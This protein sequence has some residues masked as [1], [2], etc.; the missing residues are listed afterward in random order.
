MLVRNSIHSF[1]PGILQHC[2]L[3]LPL[4]MKISFPSSV[5]EVSGT[6][7]WA[8]IRFWSWCESPWTRCLLGGFCVASRIPLSVKDG[9][10]EGASGNC[11]SYYGCLVSCSVQCQLLRL[12][13]T[14]ASLTDWG[15]GKHVSGESDAE[16]ECKL[17]QIASNAVQ[18]ATRTVST[19][20]RLCD[21]VSGGHDSGCSVWAAAAPPGTLWWEWFWRSKQLWLLVQQ[22]ISLVEFYWLGGGRDA[23]NCKC[24]WLQRGEPD[25]VRH[26]SVRL[27]HSCTRGA[28][29][30]IQGWRVERHRVLHRVAWLIL[31]NVTL[32]FTP[33]D[34]LLER[35]Y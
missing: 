32:W 6:L 9:S 23:Y 28:C 21:W 2:E 3:P 35:L 18:L 25:S 7:N 11:D 26:W 13:S 24:D 19:P 27:Q 8:V 14:P 22:V 10:C 33:T 31:M 17:W 1:F 4:Q 16:C 29:V 34:R 15:G 5:N 20:A 12:C 30:H